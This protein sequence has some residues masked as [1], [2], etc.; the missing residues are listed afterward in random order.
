MWSCYGLNILQV[1]LKPKTTK[2]GRSDQWTEDT[3]FWVTVNVYLAIKNNESHSYLTV[4]FSH[5]FAFP[6]CFACGMENGFRVYN[7]DPLREKER[8]G[9]VK[10]PQIWGWGLIMLPIIFCS[11]SV[12]IVSVRSCH[13]GTILTETWRVGN[14][15]RW[16]KAKNT[17]HMRMVRT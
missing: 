2:D 1:D 10:W 12:A 7:T 14:S 13:Y 4:I 8:Q 5:C 17:V 3:I 11:Y 6:G 9:T 15:T 16:G